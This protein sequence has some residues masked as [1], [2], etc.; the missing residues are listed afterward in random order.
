MA[1]LVA[2]HDNVVKVIGE[3]A[4]VGVILIFELSHGVNLHLIDWLA[5]LDRRGRS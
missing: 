2:R 4:N 1:A 5:H 3:D